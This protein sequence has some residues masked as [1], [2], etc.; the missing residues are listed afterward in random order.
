MT[1]FLA[2]SQTNLAVMVAAIVAVLFLTLLA[3]SLVR[4]RRTPV[5]AA[6]GEGTTEPG[7]AAAGDSGAARPGR[8]P[9]PVSRRDFFRRSLIVSFLA[10]GAQFGGASIAFLWPNLKGGF[11]STISAGSVN[12]I[13]QQIQ[14]TN[15]PFY[16]GAGRFYVVPYDGSGK[17]DSTGVDYVADGA[18][19]EG[20]MALYQRCVHLGCRVPF[21]LQSQWFECPCHGSKYSRA[22]EYKLGPAPTG[23]QRFPLSVDSSGNLLVDTSIILPGPPRGT[24]TT[25]QS[26]QGPFC[27]GSS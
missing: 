13:K 24:D 23:L 6:L 21:C 25:H 3:V 2:L 10:F 17:D 27:V 15:Q 26:A 22:G 11:G 1:A 5:H 9:A 16:Y 4:S 12:D 20:L 19:A 18:I 8:T 14:Q 7:D